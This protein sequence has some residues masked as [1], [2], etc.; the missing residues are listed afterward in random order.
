[1]Q[2]IIPLAGIALPV[3]LVPIILLFKQ[4]AQK[5]QFRHLEQM[6]AIKSGRP[7]PAA[8]QI[9]GPGSVVAI[10]AGVPTAAILGALIATANFSRHAEDL[11]PLMG[12]IWS[13]A[14]FV[15]LS[16]MATALILGI[17]AHR[18]HGRETSR[19]LDDSAKPAYDPDL[20]DAAGR[21][22]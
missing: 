8:T 6:Q 14:A 22:F 1:M 4:I 12:V 13:C 19:P 10:G 2:M 7:L 5:R 18:A 11:L 9:P 16:G 3:I 17:M 20:F 21:G 15:S